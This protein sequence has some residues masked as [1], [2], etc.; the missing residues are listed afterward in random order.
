MAFAED[1]ISFAEMRALLTH[2]RDGLGIRQ[3]GS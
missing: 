3:E 2:A 1:G